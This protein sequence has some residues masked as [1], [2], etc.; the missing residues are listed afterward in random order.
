MTDI[1]RLL[2]L[3]CS[4]G[5]TSWGYWLAGQDS[6]AAGGPGIEVHGVDIR[7]QPRF[8]WPGRFTQGDAT[9]ID[10]AGYDAYACSMPCHD[11]TP[12]KSVAGLDGTGHLLGDLRTRLRATGK[13]Y[14]IENVPGA[15][16]RA[17]LKLCGCMPDPPLRTY[18]V[19]WFELSEHF[20][21]SGVVQPA[22]RDH[23]ARTATKHRR[24]L[25]DEGWH[26]SVTGDV[27][28]YVGPEAMGID[29][30]TGN[31]LSLAVPPAYTRYA[32]RYL[33]GCVLAA[34]AALPC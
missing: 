7:P 17:D 5:G 18:R 11:H 25:W 15:P 19:R 21:G 23:S 33:I 22:H 27:G 12:L 30:M 14:V 1:I 28:T 32:G 26:V 4:A 31:E 16:M 6:V 8:P 9:T 13:P 34:R 29:W 2:D 24:K 10:L 3:G 20:A